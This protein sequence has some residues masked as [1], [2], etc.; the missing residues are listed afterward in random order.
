MAVAVAATMPAGVSD[1][2]FQALSTRAAV[3]GMAMMGFMMRRGGD[4]SG[5][6]ATLWVF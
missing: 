4:A 2:F 1:F 3:A 6:R 5:S